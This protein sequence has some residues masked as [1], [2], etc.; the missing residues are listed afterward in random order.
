MR[1]NSGTRQD[2]DGV[3]AQYANQ[4]HGGQDQGPEHG[5]E[6]AWRPRG[7]HVA[8]QAT[9]VRLRDPGIACEE[10]RKADQRLGGG[11]IDAIPSGY[12]GSVRRA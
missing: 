12:R 11:E 4:V 6:R 2:H 1:V 7:I 10:Q 8:R 9:V 3:E 5:P